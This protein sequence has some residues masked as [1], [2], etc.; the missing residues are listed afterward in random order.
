VQCCW[1]AGQLFTAWALALLGVSSP[2]AAVVAQ[3]NDMQLE[4]K[5]PC[6]IM[7]AHAL[8]QLE[9]CMPLFWG[10]V[11][12]PQSKPQ[13]L[14]AAVCWPRTGAA[15]LASHLRCH[16]GMLCVHLL[17]TRGCRDNIRHVLLQ[18]CHLT[19]GSLIQGCRC[20]ELILRTVVVIAALLATALL[21]YGIR[22]HDVG[23]SL[24][25]FG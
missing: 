19:K 2:S 20:P 6:R 8:T 16:D 23:C 3:C 24:G 5:T 13:A 11:S 9:V 1:P 25:P 14:S 10:V 7:R 21:S 22:Q 15:Q 18:Q 4:A 12:T 17:P